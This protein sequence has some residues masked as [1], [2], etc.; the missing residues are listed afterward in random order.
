MMVWCDAAE[1]L[2][3]DSGEDTILRMTGD[4]QECQ[5]FTPKDALITLITLVLGARL[6]LIEFHDALRN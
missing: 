4:G 2:C 1:A 3:M 6:E 5:Y